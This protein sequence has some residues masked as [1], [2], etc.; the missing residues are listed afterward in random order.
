MKQYAIVRQNAMQRQNATTWIVTLLAV[1]AFQGFSTPVRGDDQTLVRFWESIESSQGGIGSAVHFSAVGT[2]QLS[3][4]V[5]VE[6]RYRLEESDLILETGSGSGPK[7][8][9]TETFPVTFGADSMTITSPD[10]KRLHKKR[11]DRPP[12]EDSPLLG[13]WTY[14]DEGQGSCFERYLADGS[15]LFR[16]PLDSESGTYRIQKQRVRL[17]PGRG[18]TKK[19]WFEREVKYCCSGR[20]APRL[21]I[22]ESRVVLGTVFPTRER[23]EYTL[24]V[25]SLDRHVPRLADACACTFDLATQPVQIA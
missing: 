23:V 16:L 18:K 10:G 25:R 14:E 8:G 7:P 15:M 21:S 3:A 4:V 19:W 6:T 13:D 11:F 20:R 1:L 2:F 5:P 12:G 22:S 17:E 24:S 9:A